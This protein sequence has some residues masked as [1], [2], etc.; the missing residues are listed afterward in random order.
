VHP[1]DDI[2]ASLPAAD[3]LV[4][5]TPVGMHTS[6]AESPLEAE[7]LAR[8]KSS[9]IVYDLIYTPRPTRFLQLASQRGLTIIDGSEMLVQQGAA[10]LEIWLNQPV[11]VDT[12]RQALLTKLEG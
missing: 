6:A 8:A 12:M 5:T 1:L 10:A 11:P 2:A 3:L 7:D 9:A 4:N